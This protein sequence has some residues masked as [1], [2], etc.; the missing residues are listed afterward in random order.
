MNARNIE[1]LANRFS[2]GLLQALGDSVIAEVIAKNALPEYAGCCASH[3]YCDANEIMLQA[4]DAEG[5]EFDA[6]NDEQAA[7]CNAAWALAKQRG[8]KMAT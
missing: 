7:G 1:S 6:E 4:M 2:L 8:F 5:I 3:D